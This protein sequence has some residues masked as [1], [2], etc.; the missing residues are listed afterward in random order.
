MRLWMGGEIRRVVI[1]EL[2]R[3]EWCRTRQALLPPM[4]VLASWVLR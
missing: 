4:A 1:Y 3:S 2:V